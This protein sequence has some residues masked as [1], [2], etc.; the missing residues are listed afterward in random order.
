MN[1]GDPMTKRGSSIGIFLT[2]VVTFFALAGMFLFIPKPNDI[3][4]LALGIVL[5]V[6]VGLLA[7]RY[8]L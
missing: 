7:M 1:P 5:L 8:I 6:C 4:M 2:A 3:L